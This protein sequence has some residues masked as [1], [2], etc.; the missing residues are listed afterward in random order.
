[1][2]TLIIEGSNIHNIPTF[3]DEINRLFM[4][5]EDWKIGNSLDALNDVLYGGFSGMDA[6]EHIELTWNN[7]EA[8][9]KA[10]GYETTRT[11]YLEKLQP[12]SPFNKKHF[13]EQLEQLENN[14]GKTYFDL[15]M[16]VIADHKNITL[17][18]A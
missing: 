15:V 8:S 3:Y 11:Y 6:K 1:M 2:R 9:K 5:G 18:E 12:D 4:F 14:T 13:L 17:T 10:L 7:I 16:E